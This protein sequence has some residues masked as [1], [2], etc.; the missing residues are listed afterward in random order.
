MPEC[1]EKSIIALWNYYSR[2][3][4][5]SGGEL[6][7][8]ES[9]DVDRYLMLLQEQ[10]ENET[11]DHQKLDKLDAISRS[12]PSDYEKRRALCH[13][14]LCDM[15][16]LD[17]EKLIH[18]IKANEASAA[19]IK[20]RDIILL[21]GTTGAGKTTTIL[22]LSGCVM[23]KVK[24]KTSSAKNSKGIAHIQA[25]EF[26]NAALKSFVTS[27]STQSETRFVNAFDLPLA[28]GSLITLCDTP[29]FGDTGGLEVDLANGVG[30]VS[31]LQESRSIRPFILFSKEDAGARWEGIKTMCTTLANLFGN[32]IEH[33]E[34]FAY[35]FTR[36]SDDDDDVYEM[37]QNKQKNMAAE[38][39]SIP[40]Y[41]AFV[42]DMVKKTDPGDDDSD[43]SNALLIFPLDGKPAAVLKRLLEYPVIA[44]PSEALSFFATWQSMHKL[45]LQLGCHVKNI[46]YSF[47]NGNIVLGVYKLD[48]LAVLTKALKLKSV[49]DSYDRA[50]DCAFR[51][52]KTSVQKFLDLCDQLLAHEFK[53]TT[54]FIQSVTL[55]IEA[56]LPL[57]C[58]RD[59]YPELED[60]ASL[61]MSKFL[62]VTKEL[63][64]RF[65]KFY[66]IPSL[67][68]DGD[69]LK[70]A[71]LAY[72][73]VLLICK[74]VES[75]PIADSST[76]ITGFQN[77]VLEC[78]EHL[79]SVCS[80]AAAKVSSFASN[81]NFDGFVALSDCLFE[82]LASF[83]P[84]L[85]PEDIGLV[86]E[87][88]CKG[89][90]LLQECLDAKVSSMMESIDIMSQCTA[91][92]AS[93]YH[94]FM[95]VL[96]A[97][98]KLSSI[99]M[100]LNGRNLR[101]DFDKL[102]NHASDQINESILVLRM[103]F[104]D[105]QRTFLE[106]L[107]EIDGISK[108]LNSSELNFV[109]GG[110]YHSFLADARVCIKQLRRDADEQMKYLRSGNLKCVDSDKFNRG[111][112][113]LISARDH[114]G[115]NEF[116]LYEDEFDETA[117]DI[118]LFLRSFNEDIGSNPPTLES[119]PALL[120][121]LFLQLDV[122]LKL[123]HWHDELEIVKGDLLT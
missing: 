18:Y 93:K 33:I 36:F 100:H 82:T 91:D 6:S 119:D 104:E 85:A 94:E 78:T 123:F 83:T 41:K 21:L 120:H 80:E 116:M 59:H 84:L 15:R 8:S 17:I 117:A 23:E 67:A 4:G 42:K 61:V 3:C 9:A 44:Q 39:S 90:L 110:A 43:E 11:F 22:Y 81:L 102:L 54:E 73:K 70:L 88:Y 1:A 49:A 86:N 72:S 58:I 19:R 32:S 107:A 48:Q 10:A 103:V 57:D 118:D 87:L 92:V 121:R 89:N 98:V 108:L 27:G 122:A 5:Q 60:I 37:L 7:D 112:Q 109:C 53:M 25:K 63:A 26:P 29:G 95:A 106:C 101:D 40:F 99:S 76:Q 77:S 96:S 64:S 65:K 30:V 2:R 113:K 31:A 46:E 71:V 38:D 56:M 20:D 74:T 35:G 111:M 51:V 34:S 55:A 12:D 24:V 47:R 62:S 97:A 105:D 75:L 28:D 66:D 13:L 79:I 68:S 16:P 52:W 115:R 114:L 14:L 45:E 50:R 69:A